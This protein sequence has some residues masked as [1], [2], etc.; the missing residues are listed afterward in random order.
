MKPILL[1]L[2]VAAVVAADLTA[3]RRGR[4]NPQGGGAPPE[5]QQPAAQ[6]KAEAAPSKPKKHMALV[7][8]DVLLGTG[9]RMAGATVLIGDDKIVDVGHNLELPEGTEVVDVRGKTISPGFIAVVGNGMGG[10]RGAPF[11]DSVN[12]FDPEIKQ[13]LAAGV[14]SFLCGSPA[15]GTSPG[16]ETAVLKLAY[17]DVAGMLCEEAAV[18]GMSVPLAPADMEKFADLVK[19]SKEHRKALDEFTAKKATDPN[20]KPP[21]APQGAEKILKILAGETRLWIQLRGGGGGRRGGGGGMFGGGAAANDVDAIREAMKVAQLLGTPV[22]LQ[23]P[24]SAWLVPDEIA[25]TGSMVVLAPRD[26]VA[27]DPASPDDT[28][29]NL[30]SAAL[31]AAAGVPV[32]VT[33]SNGLMGGAGVG[34]GGILGQDLNTPHVDAAFAVRGGLENAKAL[35]T[36]TLDAARI[37]GVES[38]I[39]SV[40]AGKDADLLILDGDPLHYR[41]FVQTAIVNGKVVYEKAKEPFYS[42]IQR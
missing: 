10:G 15:G 40:E 23:R 2:V 35:R 17:G 3:Q 30:A 19:K 26:R 27:P 6:P 24:T 39:G 5:A 33:Q 21:Q 41:T 1:A 16:G 18:V 34:T 36:L 25:A 14:T 42:H 28:G 9:A 7:G 38:R 12:P 20:A 22:V 37:L 32:A 13:A 4:F 8:G 11:V 29:T 31:L